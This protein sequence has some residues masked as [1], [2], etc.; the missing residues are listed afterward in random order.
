[1]LNRQI[2]GPQLTNGDRIRL[3]LSARC[4]QFWQR[5]S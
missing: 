4:T 5:A 3:V 2:K 1:V